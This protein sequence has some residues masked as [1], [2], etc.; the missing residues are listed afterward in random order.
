MF[1]P[2]VCIYSKCTVKTQNQIM[3]KPCHIHILFA[4]IFMLCALCAAPHLY[5]RSLYHIMRRI[6]SLSVFIIQLIWQTKHSSQNEFFCF[7]SSS[8]WEYWG[9]RYCLAWL[10]TLW[11]WEI[12]VFPAFLAEALLAQALTWWK[13]CHKSQK[14]PNPLIP[15]ASIISLITIIS[16]RNGVIMMHFIENVSRLYGHKFL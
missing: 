5:I 11:L 6:S 14:G 3:Q 1:E 7:I 16:I 2:Y 15:L 13:M 12:C 4:V 10:L 9:H 8:A